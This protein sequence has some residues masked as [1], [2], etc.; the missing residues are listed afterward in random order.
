MSVVLGM[1]QSTRSFKFLDSNKEEEF[2]E[3]LRKRFQNIY[4]SCDG[5]INKFC[6]MLWNSVSPYE[7]ITWKVKNKHTNRVCKDFKIQNLGQYHDLY[8]QSDTLLLADVFESFRNK[9]IEICELDV[10]YLISPTRLTLQACLKKTKVELELLADVNMLLMVEK[11]IRGGMFYAGHMN[12]WK[13]LTPAKNDH[14]S[15]TGMLGTYVKR[16]QHKSCPLLVLN[17]ETIILTFMKTSY[18]AMMKAVAKDTSLKL[19]LIILRIYRR[20]TFLLER[21]KIDKYQN[22]V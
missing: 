6:L 8:V 18:K 12:T 20:H 3:A 11:G 16:Q 17:R 21:M 10:A 2:E 22:L 15:C 9:F 1:H 7:H 5:D 4:W 14:T 19:M 13:A